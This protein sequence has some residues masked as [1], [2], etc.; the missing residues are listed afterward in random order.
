M[1]ETQTDMSLKRCHQLCS[2]NTRPQKGNCKSIFF[3]VFRRFLGILGAGEAVNK[4]D[5]SAASPDS[6]EFQAV[7]KSAAS[8]GS[9]KPKI[10]E[11]KIQGSARTTGLG[12]T[13]GTAGRR[14]TVGRRN[15]ALPWILVSLILGFLEAAL[16]A[17]LITA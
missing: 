6:V 11:T 1:R 2:V 7:I 12:G 4:S 5:A 16:A 3:I 15:G 9:R 14:G 17:D 10:K 13:T 8:A